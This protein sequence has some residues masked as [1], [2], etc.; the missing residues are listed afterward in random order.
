MLCILFH[1]HDLLARTNEHTTEK[2][3]VFDVDLADLLAHPASSFASL[4][5][6]LQ[7]KYV[8]IILPPLYYPWQFG[9]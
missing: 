3:G 4:E 6:Y 1:A 8:Q 9:R 7:T 5:M 2:S